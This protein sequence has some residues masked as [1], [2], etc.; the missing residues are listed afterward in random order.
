MSQGIGSELSTK[1][2]PIIQATNHIY[3]PKYNTTEDPILS[4]REAGGKDETHG[5]R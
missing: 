2:N 1:V 3:Y 4:M 5:Q